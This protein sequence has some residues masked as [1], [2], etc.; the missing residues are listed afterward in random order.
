MAAARLP[1]KK[2]TAR[3]KKILWKHFTLWIKQ[4]DKYIC[5]TCDRK[6]EPGWGAH[7][8]HFIPKSIGGVELYFNE[9]NVHC[10]C[11]RC[12]L[13]EQGNQYIYGERLGKKKVKELQAIR[14]KTKN[15]VWSREDYLEKIKKYKAL[16]K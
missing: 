14:L 2:S 10:Q 7:G 4:R 12:N 11:A 15:V 5:F 8:G 13:S 16:L 9:D 6:C 3:L 1:K